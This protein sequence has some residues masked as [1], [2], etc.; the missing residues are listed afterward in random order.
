MRANQEAAMQAGAQDLTAGADPSRPIETPAALADRFAQGA[1]GLAYIKPK[2]LFL[3]TEALY[4]DP[5][6]LSIHLPPSGIGSISLLEAACLT[7]LSRIL[8]PRRIF[9]F[10][11]FLGYSTS[12]FL[13]NSE[14]DCQVVSVDLG[15]VSDDLRE[16][17]NYSDAELRSDDRKNDNHLRLTQA[18]LGPLY[19]RG[20]SEADRRRLTLLHQDSRTLDTAALGLDGQVDL[21]FVDGGHDLETIASDTAKARAMLGGSGAIVWHDFNSTIHG[22]VTRYMAGE[23]EQDIIVSVPGTLLAIGL[24]GAARDAF[25][26]AAVTQG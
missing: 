25:L 22:E 14:P 2:V 6:P 12:L 13:A 5:T 15:D 11:T 24:V 16:A 26:A 18:R 7:A 21:V 9:E 17:A 10:G 4:A 20:L 8:R 19:L 23:C 3:K 1:P